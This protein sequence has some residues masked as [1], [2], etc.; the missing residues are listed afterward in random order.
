MFIIACCLI[1]GLGLELDLVSGRAHVYLYYFRLSLSHRRFYM[2]RGARWNISVWNV[3]KSWNF[4]TLVTRRSIFQ[5]NTRGSR[6]SA[7]QFCTS[8]KIL[9]WTCIG[10]LPEYEWHRGDL[11]SYREHDEDR[12]MKLL[13]CWLNEKECRKNAKWRNCDVEGIDREEVSEVYMGN[14]VQTSLGQNPARQA[15]IFAG[16]CILPFP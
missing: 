6:S 5:S 12:W 8:N 7:L 10:R 14:V 9:L 13:I 1:A 2:Y 3:K 11:I 15:A 16:A 4:T